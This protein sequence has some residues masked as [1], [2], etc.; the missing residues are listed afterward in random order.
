MLR[1]MFCLK[2]NSVVMLSQNQIFTL[3]KNIQRVHADDS[4]VSAAS[5]A[6][7]HSALNLTKDY[8]IA[9]GNAHCT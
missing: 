3:I 4:S 1:L 5:C 2:L 6:A 8:L 7:G 9:M